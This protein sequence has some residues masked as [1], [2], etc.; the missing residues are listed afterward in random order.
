[1]KAASY[2]W[3]RMREPNED[4]AFA[5]LLNSLNA[6]VDTVPVLQEGIE[7][8]LFNAANETIDSCHVRQTNT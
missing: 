7:V 1:M 5:I 4:K 3:S 8:Y 2:P 6:V